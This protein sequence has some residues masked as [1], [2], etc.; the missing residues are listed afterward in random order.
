MADDLASG[1]VNLK[2]INQLMSLWRFRLQLR[3]VDDTSNAAI[4]VWNHEAVD[5]L[6]KTVAELKAELHEQGNEKGIPIDFEKLEEREMLFMVQVRHENVRKK[7]DVFS[8]TKL[9]A[10]PNIISKYAAVCGNFFIIE[11]GISCQSA[12]ER[13]GICLCHEDHGQE[14][15]TRENKTAYEKVEHIVFDLSSVKPHEFVQ[16]GLACLKKFAS[17]DKALHLFINK[18]GK[19]ELEVEG[20]LPEKNRDALTP[21]VNN[22]GILKSGIPELK[23]HNDEILKLWIFRK[24]DFLSAFLGLSNG[25]VTAMSAY[26]FEMLLTLIVDIEPDAQVQFVKANGEI[27]LRDY[28]EDVVSLIPFCLSMKL[29]DIYGLK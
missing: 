2:T 12:E 27:S 17:L 21:G 24:H 9:S 6:G 22:F 28:T 19:K 8:V 29:K 14:F 7:S 25:G 18:H 20:E 23:F 10:D 4:L 26:G 15:V 5:L 1:N 3:V 11:Y 13:H 16:Y